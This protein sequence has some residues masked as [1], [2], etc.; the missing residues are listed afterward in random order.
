MLVGYLFHRF[1]SRLGKHFDYSSMLQWFTTRTCM[2]SHL[3][4]PFT[5][6]HKPSLR[7]NSSETSIT[8]PSCLR[9]ARQVESAQRLLRNMWKIWKSRKPRLAGTG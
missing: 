3:E 8:A 2:K 4:F 7:L 6:I 5:V 9:N 1:L